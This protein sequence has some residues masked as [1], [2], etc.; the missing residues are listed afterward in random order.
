MRD[1]ECEPR[2]TILAELYVARLIDVENKVDGAPLFKTEGPLEHGCRF[3]NA[4]LAEKNYQSYARRRGRVAIQTGFSD[5]GRFVGQIPA[6]LAIERLQGRL[7]EAMEKNG[8]ADVAALIFNTHGESMGR[9]AHPGSR[10]E[11]HTSELQSLMRISY[12]VFCLK[13]KNRQ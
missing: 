5:A 8:L 2:S 11:E 6:S 9:G 7:C 3:L 4:L 12:A 1:A 10:S 13:K